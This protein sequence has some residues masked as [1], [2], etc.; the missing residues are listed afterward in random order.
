[1]LCVLEKS[2]PKGIARIEASQTPGSANDTTV[3]TRTVGNESGRDGNDDERDPEEI[4][5]LLKFSAAK[6]VWCDY[7]ADMNG[8]NSWDCNVVEELFK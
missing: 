2:Q 7:R 6:I 3:E 4:Y 8:D 1:M 5:G